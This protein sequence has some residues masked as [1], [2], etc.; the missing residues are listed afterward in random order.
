MD[1][2]EV[3]LIRRFLERSRSLTPDRRAQ[4]AASIAGRLRTRVGGVDRE[5]PDEEFLARVLAEKLR[6]T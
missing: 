4:L 3:T 5:L 1:D 6:H 2:E